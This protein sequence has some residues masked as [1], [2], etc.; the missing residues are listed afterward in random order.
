MNRNKKVIHKGM[1]NKG[2]Q[3]GKRKIIKEWRK[4]EEQRKE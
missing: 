1:R 4:K 2:N 3:R